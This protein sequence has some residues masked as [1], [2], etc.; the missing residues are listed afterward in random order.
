[1]DPVPHLALRA[2]L[3][4]LFL[5]AAA[6]K[7]R[8]GAAFR[9]RLTAYDLL[10]ARAVPAAAVLPIGAEL[11]AAVW[12]AWPTASPAWGAGP[13]LLLAAYSAAIAINLVRGRAHIDCGC[14]AESQPLSGALVVRNAL[15]IA[16]LLLVAGPPRPRA[17]VWFDI[18]TAAALL[19]AMCLL[20]AAV[21]RALANRHAAAI[22]LTKGIAP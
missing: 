11:L 12:C 3:A 22:T 1:M 21:N 19:M 20:Y 2:A 18:V 17:L 14:G 8:D 15:L 4:L 6:H 13:A 7:L 5:S 16:A 10:P 9:A